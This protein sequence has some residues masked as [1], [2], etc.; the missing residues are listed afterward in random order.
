MPPVLPPSLQAGV[1]GFARWWHQKQTIADIA[2]KI[3]NPLFQYTDAA[4]IK[5][6]IE[7]QEI[8]LTS[9]FHLNDPSELTHGIKCAVQEIKEF[10]SKAVQQNDGIIQTACDQV[11]WLI[12]RDPRSE[13]AFFVASFS[14]D[15]D[16]LGQWRAYGDDGRGFAVGFA[17]RLFHIGDTADP[18]KPENNVFVASVTYGDDVIRMK[19]REAIHTAFDI[20]CRTV[21][22]P[23]CQQEISRDNLLGDVFID[24]MCTSLLVPLMWNSIT[25]KHR[26][27]KPEQEVRLIILGHVPLFTKIEIRTRG[28]KLVPFIKSPMATQTAGNITKVMVGPAADSTAE[29]E[30]RNLL[31][32]KGI[33]PTNLVFR[34]EIPYRGR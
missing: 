5:G 29:D 31:I 8:W 1:D 15:P 23:L 20:I 12:T 21:A 7:N 33:N 26:A 19:H 6:I 30:V 18:Q 22:N 4:G 10:Y 28:S 14:R 24:K 27:Y 2:D 3:T 25:T 17:P 16:D 34:S 9:L 11:E 13:L 32:A